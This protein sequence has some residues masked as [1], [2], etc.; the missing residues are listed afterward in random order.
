MAKPPE[1]DDLRFGL[2]LAEAPDPEAV[3]EQR[4]WLEE[5]ETAPTAKRWWEF[6]KLVDQAISRA[7]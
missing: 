2:Q 1:L 7:R 6:L 3:E 5:L 4:A